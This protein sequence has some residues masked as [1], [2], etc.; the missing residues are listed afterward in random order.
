[1]ELKGRKANAEK[2]FLVF[3]AS[4][5]LRPFKSTSHGTGQ[6]VILVVLGL[7]DRGW[8]WPSGCR[9]TTG[10]RL[11]VADVVRAANVDALRAAAPGA[12]LAMAGPFADGPG[13]PASDHSRRPC[14]GVPRARPRWPRS[15]TWR[16]FPKSNSSPPG[17]APF[18]MASSIVA[19]TG[20]NGK[21]DRRSPPT[22]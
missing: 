20:S 10:A 16:W 19:I 21:I 14:G 12:E 7:G 5:R 2:V 8:R 13:P 17:S 6:K 22:S 4:L 15:P 18:A 3:S 1:M 9:Q 11:R